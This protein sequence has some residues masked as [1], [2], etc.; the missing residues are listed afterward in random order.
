M[1]MFRG[2]GRA[3][4]AARNRGQAIVEMAMALTLL[5]VLICG[6]IDFGRALND[7][8]TIADLTRQGSNLASRGTSLTEAA[9]AVISGESGLD[10]ANHGM[11][12]ITSV[13]N[14]SSVFTIS[15]QATQGALSQTSKIGT[16]V[17]TNVTS[18]LPTA[19]KNSLQN[20]QS[21]YIT[22]I[23]YSFTS[24][25]PIGALTNSVI[26]MPSLL[27]DSAYF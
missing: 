9:A 16:G 2:S 5:L 27:Y 6:S 25:T 4:F 10:L 22:E 18:T 24:L 26:N 23:Y 13:T 12:I 8:Q 17:G 15:G 11:V 7:L 20:G 3:M 1:A 14:N 19:A 21:I